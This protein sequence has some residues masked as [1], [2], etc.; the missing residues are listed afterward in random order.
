M[1]R[2]IG[3]LMYG[4]SGGPTSVINASAYGVISKAR[5]YKEN[6]ND[7]YVMKHGIQGA[8]NEEL[9]LINE[10]YDTDIN[11]LVHTPGS[12]FG[13]VRYKLKSE[14]EDNSDYIRLLEVFKKYNIRYFLYNGGNDS[15]DTCSK[16][17]A[18]MKKQSYDINIIGVPKTIDN[19]L[20]FTDHTPGYGSAAKYISNTMAEICYDMYAYPIGKVTIVEIMGRHAGWLTASS[21][22][23]S[24]NG[25][26]PDLIY[27]PE[28]PFSID[29][30]KED[31]K[32]VYNEK[33]NCLVAVSEGI[34][35]EL[36]EFVF[37]SKKKDHFGHSQLGGVAAKLSQLISQDLKI[38]TRSVELSSSQRSASHFQSI[39]DVSEAIA[40]GEHA[41][42]Y[43]I[44]GLSDVMVGIERVSSAP[45]Q[46]KYNYFNL[47]K[48][49]NEEKKLTDAMINKEGNGVT[50]V[51]IQYALPLIQGENKP[52]YHLGIQTFA[53]IK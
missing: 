10:K 36:G 12:A 49:A 34:V 24:I 39:V 19:D 25:F 53:K 27:L 7:I 31:V 46:V 50:D 9:F 16:I 5:E 35:N 51:F 43:A 30:F 18:F 13:S 42:E 6:I 17:A 20:P 44:N 37:A 41:V 32:R 4:Q 15:M 45:Y 3:N 8:L 23:A 52:K 11:L 21:A 48:C 22:L 1:K 29:K 38:A 33:K 26:G 14:V 2:L 40:V 28:R 47:E